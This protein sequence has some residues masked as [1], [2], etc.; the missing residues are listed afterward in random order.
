[1]LAPTAGCYGLDRWLRQGTW[2][3]PAPFLSSSLP[4]AQAFEVMPTHP[5]PGASRRGHPE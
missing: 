4:P 5:T 3:L 2:I 1:M